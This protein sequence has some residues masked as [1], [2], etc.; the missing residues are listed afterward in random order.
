MPIVPS[1]GCFVERLVHKVQYGIEAMGC[2]V[3]PVV[4]EGEGNWWPQEMIIL[5]L[6]WPT[7]A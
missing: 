3:I 7:A 1:F 2:P 4:M 5:G 6:K